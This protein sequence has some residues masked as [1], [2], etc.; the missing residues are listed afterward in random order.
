MY[1]QHPTLSL[2]PSGVKKIKA[3]LTKYSIFYNEYNK[4]K[5]KIDEAIKV[6]ID[7][8]IPKD[9]AGGY[10]HER[11]REN[12][13]L[14]QKA[15][16][17]YQISED[18]KY[19]E[20]VKDVLMDYA[21]KYQMFDKHPSDK[22]YARGKF[23][24]QCLNDAVWM[25]FTSQAYD[26]IYNYLSKEER[27]HLEE[28]L[29]IPYANFLSEDN[30]KFF[31]RVH[32]HSTWANAAVG[33]IALAMEN[34][35][36]LQKALYGLEKDGIDPNE[37]DNDGGFLKKE[38]QTK[39]GFYAQL[40]YSFAPDGYFSEGPYYQRY[41]IFPF[42]IFSYALH[43]AKPDLNIFEHREAILKKA[44]NSLLQLTNSQGEFFPIND[45]QKGM[46][47]NA[48]E[49]ITAVDIMHLIDDTQTDL[50]AWAAAQG[51]VTLDEAGFYIAK[52]IDENKQLDNPIKKSVLFGDG[53]NG[54]E[55]GI[56]ILRNQQTDLLF[57]FSSQGMGH[58]HFDRL[59]YALYNDSGEVV[60][61]Y[62]AVRWVNIDQ[63]GGGRYLPENK[64]F[65]KQSIAHNTITVDK[66]SHYEASVKKAEEA[67]P[68]LYLFDNSNEDIQVVSAIENNAYNDVDMQRTLI[69]IKD[70]EF[71][72]PL[73]IDLF[74]LKSESNHT[75]DMAT[76]YSGHFMKSN[77]TCQNNVTTLKPLGNNFGY[78]HIWEKS[79][80]KPNE[81]M[82]T[83]TWFGKNQ[84][85][86]KYTPA[87]T[88]DQFIAG[89]AGANDPDQ[90]LRSDPVL[91][92][93][94]ENESNTVFLN[95]LE[96]HG[97]YSY[98][99]EVPTQPY[100]LIKDVKVDYNDEQYSAF[101]F[102]TDNNIWQVYFASKNNNAQQKHQI[103]FNNK[104]HTWSGPID[105]TKT[106][107]NN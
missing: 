102:K 48:Y 76:W 34:D 75:Y 88:T 19:A 28:K 58:G 36:L 56:A 30:P 18:E 44:T 78:Q 69:M 60:Q 94:K 45:A 54:D 95:I 22:S 103:N 5:A 71:T 50:V 101:H 7:V 20:F 40:D 3:D 6:G 52:K 100:G 82:H 55:G 86:T 59:A 63:K 39:A 64:T 14:L 41:A 90:N 27:N 35:E 12:Y 77:S 70:V 49:L 74:D 51:K 61:D 107:T 98:S 99:T 105:I 16:N 93:R 37:F 62:G 17:I 47:L 32:N 26:C 80:C 106:K 23:F 8:P 21:E 43:N 11:H 96:S 67:H 13:I 97:T 104:N 89:M 85:F 84:L 4:V 46:N 29:F 65:G 15:G 68:E 1:A 66:T 42:L 25:V 87:N 31:N 10:T 91:I 9:M 53:V 92:H 57:K 72:K 2:T 81:E 24:W 79:N 33:M 73:I 83:I 38:G